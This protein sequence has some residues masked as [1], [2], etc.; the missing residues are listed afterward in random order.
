MEIPRQLTFKGPLQELQKVQKYFISA[1]KSH[2]LIVNT[3]SDSLF[4]K[5]VAKFVADFSPATYCR[6]QKKRYVP[7]R[8]ALNNTLCGT[9][10]LCIIYGP[11]R[12]NGPIQ[13]TVHRGPVHVLCKVLYFADLV[14]KLLCAVRDSAS[15]PL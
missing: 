1:V 4:N 14:R 5:C 13:N 3:S 7:Y 8:N 10:R 6:P 15:S 12:T 9:V 11:D 2:V